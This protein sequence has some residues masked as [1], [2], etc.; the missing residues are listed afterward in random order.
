MQYSTTSTNER[1]YWRHRW[2]LTGNNGDVAEFE[3]LEYQPG[4][5][6]DKAHDDRDAYVWIHNQPWVADRL[7][8]HCRTPQ[9]PGHQAI[10]GICH[11][12]RDDGPCYY[13]SSFK[14]GQ[15]LLRSW[16]SHSRDDFVIWR[17]LKALDPVVLTG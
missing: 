6:R 4:P 1:V 10:P 15:Q 13:A 14:R 16:A 7:G 11:A 17:E 3:V 9:Y 8:L 12:L 5:L 2:T